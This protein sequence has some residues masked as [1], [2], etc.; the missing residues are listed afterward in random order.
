M[1]FEETH[2]MDQR[3]RFIEDAH[4]SLQSFSALC[5]HYGIS[6][7]TGYKW[8]DRWLNDGPEGLEKRSSRP[9][10]SPWVTSSEV[11][12]AILAV[13]R[14]QTD[15]GGKKVRWTSSAIAP[16]CSC[17]REPPFTTF[18]TDM[19]WCPSGANA[20]AAGIQDAHTRKRLRPT[21]SGRRTLKANSKPATAATLL[22][23]RSLTAHRRAMLPLSPGSGQRTS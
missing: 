14:K 12:E 11:V 1:P 9:H 22:L 5:R 10:S 20:C 16:S 17:R 6:R 15:Y 21:R 23:P 13:R 19:G 3:R 18:C 8:L 7:K 2:V 4:C